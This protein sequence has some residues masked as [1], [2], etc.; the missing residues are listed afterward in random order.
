ML[1][2]LQKI[3][4]RAPDE[5]TY[6]GDAQA[7]M[8]R[9]RVRNLSASE[10]PVQLWLANHQ[11]G[12]AELRLG[13]EEE[14]LKAY[15]R[16]H[17]LLPQVQHLPDRAINQMVFDMAVA[18]LRYGETE[19]CCQRHTAE[20]CIVPIEGGGI[21]QD[22]EGSQ[23][24]IK[25]LTILLQRTKPDEPMH[26]AARW[27]LNLAYMTLGNFPESV[28]PQY[29]I[30][31]RAWQTEAP[32]VR[33]VDV[34]DKAGV[35][36]FSLA[37]GAI[38]DDFDNDGHIDLV[39]SSS[40]P[41][42]QLQIFWNQGDGTF[43]DGTK[44]AGITGICG[45]LNL[46]QTDY[47]N[48]GYLDVFVLRGGWLDA[49]GHH[50]NSLL[51]NNG[52]RTFTDVTYNAGLAH[53][54]FPTQTAAWADYDL[55]GDLD[56]FIGNESTGAVVAPSQLFRNNGDGTFIDVTKSAGIANSALAKAVAWGDFDGDRFPDLYI[57]NFGAENRL[58]KN[59][60][61]GTFVDV[62]SQLGV[63]QPRHSFP[64]WF[65]D[66]DNDG[67]LDLFVSAY[68]GGI[69]EVAAFYLQKPFDE[70][71][72]LPKLYRGDGQGG[73]VESAR[74][75]NLVRPT[76]PMGANF[77]DL[78][79]DGF[80][81]FYLGTG[82]P[83]FHE[84]M[85]NVLYRNEAGRRFVDVTTA[86]RVGHLQ[87]GHAVVFADFDEDGDQDIFEQMGGFVPGDKYRDVL[88]ENPHADGN[89][90]QVKLV[91]TKSN[92]AAIGS[93]I[94]VRVV[95][96]ERTRSIYKHVNSGGSF[97]A[98]PLRQHI[99]LGKAS[100]IESVEIFWPTTGQTEVFHDVPVNVFI[101]IVE[102]RGKVKIIR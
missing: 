14:S 20:S 87:K 81:D 50:P 86:A 48:D 93:R 47:N 12:K 9:E 16:A 40:D 84:L 95:E 59:Q 39:V 49:A 13:R 33:F 10:D 98:N 43:T 37:G 23:L 96:E 6:V 58:F 17:Q 68:V 41:A 31:P 44:Q 71:T 65:W 5:N 69:A 78:D 64:V 2:Q 77:G 34:A 99:G 29:L 1:D 60:G 22:P 88:Y 24:A 101:E 76:H 25:Y 28:P 18:C 51:K 19:N 70:E 100:K 7:R 54:A 94:H 79:N 89:W 42:G 67:H 38:G 83:E 4:Q 27:L 15:T 53:P 3:M 61:D 72:T 21:H 30:P 46:V 73:F 57:S 45:G 63:G 92:R 102:G 35:A 11:L 52:D 91:G 85:P 8:L 97:G 74:D 62:A 80:L 75:W 56:V 66:M 55:D 90:L 82:W 36:T 32:F 26:M